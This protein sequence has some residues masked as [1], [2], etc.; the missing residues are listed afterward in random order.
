M[1]MQEDA[2]VD[3]RQVLLARAREV[4]YGVMIGV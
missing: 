4:P 1:R 3:E 2:G